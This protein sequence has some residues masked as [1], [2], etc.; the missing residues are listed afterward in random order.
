VGSRIQVRVADHDAVYPLLIDP[1]IQPA[2]WSFE[3][4]VANASL[5][6]SRRR[7]AT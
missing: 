3:P 2:S 6:V 1:L 5:G 7:P 4:N